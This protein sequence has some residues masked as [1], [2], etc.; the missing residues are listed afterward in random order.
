MPQAS[1]TLSQITLE[2]SNLTGGIVSCPPALHPTPGQYWLAHAP[3]LSEPLPTPLFAARILAE[4]LL[5]APP[6]PPEWASGTELVVRGPLGKGFHLPLMARAVAL[7]AL[8]AV[9]HRLL[10]LM[11]VA[12]QQGA[13]VALYTAVVP[14]GLPD[15]VEI[16]PLD[17]LPEA[18]A[19]AD[20]LALDLP[21]P[22]LPDL[23]HLLGLRS[24]ER[25]S[26]TAQALVQTA[27]PCGG[28]A[29]CGICAVPYAHSYKLACKDGPV[30][31]LN[32]LLEAQ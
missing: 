11:D 26:C 13:S 4:G 5:L 8:G 30:F 20:Y 16:L 15:E 12:L 29:E 25:V 27:M 32:P 19:W 14:R 24:F 2:A 22:R 9:P 23:P 1:L 18:R 31:D 6:L 7:A 21:L 3:A 28:L 10:P 17:L